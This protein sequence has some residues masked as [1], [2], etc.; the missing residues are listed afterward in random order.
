MKHKK[1]FIL[2]GIM[3]FLIVIKVASGALTDGL[4]SH[5]SFDPYELQTSG[6][7]SS[8]PTWEDGLVSVWHFNGDYTDSIGGIDLTNNGTVFA[9]A[10]LGQGIDIEKD[11]SDW[12]NAS[13]ND[14][15]DMGTDNFTVS[16]WF[17]AES[18]SAG[19]VLKGD[20][21]ANSGYELHMVGDGTVRFIL[22]DDTNNN[23]QSGGSYA[24]GS[25]HHILGTRDGDNIHLYVDGGLIGSDAGNDAIDVDNAYGIYIGKRSSAINFD[26]IIDEVII[27]NKSLSATE[28]SQLYNASFGL[29]DSHGNNDLVDNGTDLD[30]STKGKINISGDYEAGNK[31]SLHVTAD[32]S[33]DVQYVTACVWVTAED[34]QADST[35]ILNKQNTNPFT[36]GLQQDNANSEKVRFGIRLDGDEG[37]LI[38]VYENNAITFDNRWYHYCGTFNGTETRL[39]KNGTLQTDIDTTTG[40]IDTDSS[41][42][43]Y[44]GTHPTHIQFWDGKIDLLSIWN[45]SLSAQE[46]LNLY[47]NESDSFNITYDWS[48]VTAGGGD[49]QAPQ[50]SLKNSSFIS[51]SQRTEIYF[52]VTDETASTLDC[53]LY[54]GSTALATNAT[55]IN[56]STTYLNFSNSDNTNYT[57]I[58]VNCSDGTNTNQS[59]IIWVYID[60]NNAPDTPTMNNPANAS[61]QSDSPV[62]LDCY[63]GSDLDGDAQNLR[64]YGASNTSLLLLEDSAGNHTYNWSVTSGNTYYWLCSAW[65]GA[66]EVNSTMREFTTNFDIALTSEQALWLEEIY[67]YI[68]RDSFGYNEIQ[69]LG[70]DEI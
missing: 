44:V 58:Y 41:G 69:T 53:I 61:T 54:N 17:K 16:Y 23:V 56:A 30:F 7:N 46:I 62:T 45:R 21:D 4:V 34:N 40:T 32:S 11:E 42:G 37:T 55:V 1:L 20:I 51:T 18:A 3:M 33:L 15:L 50:V 14:K 65:D 27:W 12:V 6:M 68:T 31:D 63:L 10:K 39:Y 49:T 28:I 66:I 26:G 8:F 70:Y 5:W 22:N 29:F 52:N 60:F 24:D 38:D 59:E 36:Y 13:D 35:F 25:W 43:L 19:G 57:S 2:W 48:P 47:N 9:N 67:N 64:Y